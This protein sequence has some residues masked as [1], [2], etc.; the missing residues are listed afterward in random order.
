M[1]HRLGSLLFFTLLSCNAVFSQ[2]LELYSVN[3]KPTEM[4]LGGMSPP[5]DGQV[6]PSMALEYRYP[7]VPL[8]VDGY[9]VAPNNLRLEQVHIYV[10][11]GVFLMTKGLREPSTHF[12]H[13]ARGTYASRCLSS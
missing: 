3:T 7:Q 8:E 9:A 2:N 11:H 4:P 13:C 1:K 10:R 6:V 5:K 12:M